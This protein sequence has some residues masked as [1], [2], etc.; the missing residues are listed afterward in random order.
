MKKRIGM[1][2][3][4]IALFVIAIVSCT[5]SEKINTVSDSTKVK[6]DSV[7]VDSVKVDSVK[8]DSVKV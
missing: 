5:N 2:A 6:V 8:T 3:L 7:K 1:F 4:L